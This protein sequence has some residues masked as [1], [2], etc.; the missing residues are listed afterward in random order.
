M[1]SLTSTKS[2]SSA[3]RRSALVCGDDHA[4]QLL[5]GRIRALAVEH[6]LGAEQADALGTEGARTGRILGGVGVGADAQAA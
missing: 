4:A 5:E 3:A 2:S 1:S 6:V